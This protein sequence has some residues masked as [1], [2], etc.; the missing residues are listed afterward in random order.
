MDFVVFVVNFIFSTLYVLLALRALVPI[1]S[2]LGPIA[3]LTDP[4][5]KPIRLAL[6]PQRLGLD[7][8]PFIAIIFAWLVQRL[9]LVA[10]T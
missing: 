6:P 1:I 7:V 2:W 8:S 4:M 9:I 3:S 5:L 10:I